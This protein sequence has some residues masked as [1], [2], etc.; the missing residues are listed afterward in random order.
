MYPQ[1]LGCAALATRVALRVDPL[2]RQLLVNLF[3]T[4]LGAI[5]HL[6]CFEIETASEC[7]LRVLCAPSATGVHRSRSHRCRKGPRDLF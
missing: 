6:T 1:G 2:A 7:A 4:R 3:R 5:F